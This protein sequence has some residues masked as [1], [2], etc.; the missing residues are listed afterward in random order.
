VAGCVIHDHSGRVL[1]LH[2]I[3]SDRDQWEIPG[4]KVELGESPEQCA[5]REVREELGVTVEVGR[6]IGM[7]ELDHFGKQILYV[8]FHATIVDGETPAA[9]ATCC[10]T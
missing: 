1:V 4:G 8:W 7:K 2:R 5:R 3:R 6:C 10:V 9:G